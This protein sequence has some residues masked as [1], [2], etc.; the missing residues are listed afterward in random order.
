[1]C[2]QGASEARLFGFPPLHSHSNQ[3]V[4]PGIFVGQKANT[5]FTKSDL[6]FVFIAVYGRLGCM[7]LGRGWRRGGEAA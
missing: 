6:S 7:R 4:K 2:C 3:I 5:E 1:M